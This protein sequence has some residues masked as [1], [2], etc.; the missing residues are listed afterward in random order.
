MPDES[1]AIVFSRPRYKIHKSHPHFLVYYS[2]LEFNRFFMSQST[3]VVK[4]KW[5]TML[6]VFGII[7][8]ISFILLVAIAMPLNYYFE[9][10]KA[11]A[12]MGS[13]HGGLFAWY[14]FYIIIAAFPLK[15]RPFAVLGGILGAILPAGPFVFE[16]YLRKKFA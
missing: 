2:N 12:V 16:Y 14:F 7:E 11:V 3:N 6:S 9:M 5:L 15:L 4:S 13:L 10:P 1:Y 8:G